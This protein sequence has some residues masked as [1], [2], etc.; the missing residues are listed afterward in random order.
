M[1]TIL[2]S[3]KEESRRIFYSGE[4]QVWDTHR[5]FSRHLREMA[6]PVPDH[7]GEGNP[8]DVRPNSRE[9]VTADPDASSST[10]FR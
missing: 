7:R 2:A 6:S 1:D 8:E 4:K 5:D 9:P 10:S 3:P